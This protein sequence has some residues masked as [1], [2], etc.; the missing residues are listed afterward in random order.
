MNTYDI[1]QA[2]FFMLVLLVLTPLL[3]R[4]GQDQIFEQMDYTVHFHIS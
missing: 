2:A 1:I 4:Y 3:G